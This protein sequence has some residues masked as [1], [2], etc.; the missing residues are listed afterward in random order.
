M[1]EAKVL[2]SK[3]ILLENDCVM[4]LDYSLVENH[5][6]NRLQCSFYGVRITK[7]LNGQIEEDEVEGLSISKDRVVR[8]LDKLCRYE[9][10]PISLVDVLDDL[11][12][13][14]ELTA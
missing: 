10:T 1:K 13:L 12:T 7:Y 5:P 2:F 4:K 6:E 11:Q 14:E 3:E 8:I 9:V